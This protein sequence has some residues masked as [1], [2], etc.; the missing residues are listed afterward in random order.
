MNDI[1]QVEVSQTS[2]RED[3]DLRQLLVGLLA[4]RS[5][6][7]EDQHFTAACAAWAPRRETSLLDLLVGQGR[8][9]SGDVALLLLLGERQLE[10]HGGSVEDA[11]AADDVPQAPRPLVG[12]YVPDR[13]P[14]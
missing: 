10:R 9:R 3:D 12:L 14:L 1:S 6:L 13:P 8:L 4:V 2:P 11:L 7:L 5:G